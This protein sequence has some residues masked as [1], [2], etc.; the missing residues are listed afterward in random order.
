MVVEGSRARPVGPNQRAYDATEQKP[1]R[2]ADDDPSY[3]RAGS[4]LG[5]SAAVEAEFRSR[6]NRTADE[7]TANQT[8]A[9]AGPEVA[10]GTLSTRGASNRGRLRADVQPL[11]DAQARREEQGQDDGREETGHEKPP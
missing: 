6:P 9:S 1:R 4:G 8:D 10:P 5:S 2:S 3:N 11:G 7:G